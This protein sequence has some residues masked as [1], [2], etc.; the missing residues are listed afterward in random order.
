M[1]EPVGYTKDEVDILVDLIKKLD[2]GILSQREY[3]LEVDKLYKQVQE[4]KK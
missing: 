4:D 3:M 2:I 1:L